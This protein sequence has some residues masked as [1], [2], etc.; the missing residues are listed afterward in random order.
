MAIELQAV[1]E[2]ELQECATDVVLSR[3]E[4]QAIASLP[5]RRRV[6]PIAA[7]RVKG[8]GA[9][10]AEQY[11][12]WARLVGMDFEPCPLEPLDRHYHSFDARS[13]LRRDWKAKDG[14]SAILFPEL[15]DA[16]ADAETRLA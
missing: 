10:P 11:V 6:D 15:A 2:P 12:V 3:G 16:A 7:L 4:I 14:Q 5:G 1:G 8:V 13:H 9:Q